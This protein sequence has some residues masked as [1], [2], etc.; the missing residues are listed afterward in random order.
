MTSLD[1]FL[2]FVSTQRIDVLSFLFEFCEV[3]SLERV[4][5]PFYY[6]CYCMLNKRI[7]NFISV[8]EHFPPRNW[9]ERR[10]K[11]RQIQYFATVRFC[12]RKYFLFPTVFSCYFVLF[13][14]TIFFKDDSEYGEDGKHCCCVALSLK[15]NSE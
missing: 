6:C 4:F 11:N 14:S 3:N 12:W 8:R 13:H 1:F 9:N 15:F 2:S 5:I 10:K 7:F